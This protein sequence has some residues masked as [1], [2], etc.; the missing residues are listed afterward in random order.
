MALK[1]LSFFSH[2]MKKW[3]KEKERILYES[4]FY[5]GMNEI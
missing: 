4:D 2:K 5:I 1:N 3:N